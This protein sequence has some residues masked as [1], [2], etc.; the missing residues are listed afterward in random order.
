VTENR[1]KLLEEIFHEA[2]DLEGRDRRAYL[3][4][5][6]TDDPDLLCEVE[7]LLAYD[8]E[9]ADSTSTDKLDRARDLLADALL[10]NPM[11]SSHIDDP[12][13][14]PDRIGQYS[15]L[16]KIGEG[17]MG[18]VY[19][20]E[21]DT[22]RRRVALKMIRPE[23]FT[24]N[25]LK[26]FQFET[27]ILG[28]LQ[29]PG[30]AQIHQAGEIKSGT[31]DLPYFA[32]EYVEGLPLLK[33]AHEYSISDRRKLELIARI[34]DAVHHAHQKGI[35]HRDLKPDNVLVVP[36]PSA[37]SKLGQPKVLDF[38]V[39]RATD[40]DVQMTTLHTDVGQLVGTITYMSPEQV[41]GDSRNLDVR[42]DIYA[43]GVMLYELLSGRPPFN[44]KHKSIPEAARIIREQE[45]T[46]L[47]SVDTRF[48]GD[49][50]TIAYKA[51]EKDRDRRYSS[52]ADLA[53]DIRRYL[54]NEPIVAHPP[55]T[56]YELKKFASRHR[57][58]VTG[59]SIAFLILVAGIISS[60]TF[61]IRAQ[62]GETAAQR[63]A[64]RLNV[65][66]AHA[67][68]DQDPLAFRG[69]EWRHIHANLNSHVAEFTGED[70]YCH[71]G[72]QGENRLVGTIQ[73]DNTVEQ[74]DI[75]TGERTRAMDNSK[76][77]LIK[78]MT[79]DTRRLA[80]YNSL[81][82]KVGVWDIP[83]QKYIFDL[84]LEPAEKSPILRLS[85][86]GDT[87]LIRTEP[88]RL[89]IVDLPTG[90]TTD[91][92]KNV[93]DGSTIR[94]IA[95][96]HNGDCFAVGSDKFLHLYSKSGELL[97]SSSIVE[98]ARALA[99]SPSGEYLATGSNQRMITLHDGKS[100]KSLFVLHGHTQDVQLVTFSPDGANIA[101][102]AK[103]GTIRIWDLSSQ[104]TVRVLRGFGPRNTV[105]SLTFSKDGAY[106]ALGVKGAMRLWNWR[107]DAAR[108]QQK[109]ADQY[110]YHVAFSPDSSLILTVSFYEKAR[111]W[112]AWTLE[113]LFC[114]KETASK[115]GAGFTAD[116]ARLVS[117]CRSA[118]TGQLSLL[119]CD[120][121][122]PYLLEKPRSPA[123]GI[124]F[125]YIPKGNIGRG[126]YLLRALYGNAKATSLDGESQASSW[127]ASLKASS[128]YSKD[129]SI[130]KLNTG[131]KLKVIT[132]HDAEMLSVAFSPDGAR[133]AT[134]DINGCVSVWDYATGKKL[135]TMKGHTGKVYSVSFSPDGKRIASGGNDCS[136][137][138]WDASTCEQMAVF[139]E[140]TSYVHSVAFSPDG[141][142]L[143][144]VS[145]DGMVYTW[146]SLRPAERWRRVKEAEKLRIEAGPMVDDLLKDLKDHQAVADRLRANLDLDPGLRQAALR[147][148]LER[149]KQLDL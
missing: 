148:L 64:H 8:S 128:S 113:P 34:A 68:S 49:I 67:L 43:L 86:L 3:E 12:T 122:A 48:R 144:S 15:I 121:S 57:G 104:K 9:D 114:L 65:I 41:E 55:S 146:D 54:S 149:F 23:C 26:R 30:I 28:K 85:P 89:K 33:Y 108:R 136:V 72:F 118:E 78:H 66:A 123:D 38:G 132:G 96:D 143:A 82:N 32:M 11:A 105:E 16:E 129:I 13:P 60:L 92:P 10:G 71:L 134:G 73:R 97:A 1:N 76:K 29:H 115:V 90:H 106:L 4:K 124:L 2:A 91:I 46:R 88:N 131:E 79:Y 147:V 125:S 145:G 120:P 74:V 63:T 19:L 142:M 52:A 81:E 17:G 40:A 117:L 35:V 84:A 39:A 94:Q 53:A 44:L 137:I 62:R 7:R 51:L 141:L 112:D 111:L 75:I 95:F 83:A 127:D 61:G 87:L 80:M 42:S 102:A 69:L 107:K 37:K 45:P 31:N 56:F 126:T 133:L 135:K 77:L 14:I 119:I 5:A 138:L 140:N 22:P 101:S 50:D 130:S 36:S 20:A 21:Q 59:M 24:K 100:L 6:C 139:R 58:L 27:E 110:L 99:F 98:S 103:D 25:M 109:S 116:G 18:A 47:G 93:K 70:L